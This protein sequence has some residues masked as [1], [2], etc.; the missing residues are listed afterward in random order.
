MDAEAEYFIRYTAR[1]VPEDFKE[2][3]K[4]IDELIFPL[5]V[6]YNTLIHSVEV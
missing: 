2:V 5:S 1:W 6:F 4:K 3:L